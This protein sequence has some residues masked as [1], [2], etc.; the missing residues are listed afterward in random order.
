M[1]SEL[2]GSIH[3]RFLPV[4]HYGLKQLDQYLSPEDAAQRASGF[5]AG[6]IYYSWVRSMGKNKDH[7]L[8]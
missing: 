5:E 7:E 3:G 4:T 6:D 1:L 8:Y 2:G